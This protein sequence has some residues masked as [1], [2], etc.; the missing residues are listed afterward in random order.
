MLDDA[1]LTA[2]D[3]MTRDVAVVDPETSI[4]EAVRLIAQRR[5]SGMPVVD[6]AGTVVG[7]VTEGDLV[8]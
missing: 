1:P 4:L 2:S 5:I 3:L 7:M 6:Y 8:R